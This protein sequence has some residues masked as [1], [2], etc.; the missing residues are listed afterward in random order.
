MNIA[1]SYPARMANPARETDWIREVGRRLAQTRIALGL[2]QDDLAE[3]LNVSRGALGNWEQGSRLADPGA[4]A[5]M[6]RRH[7][8]TMDWIYLGDP[9]GL[10]SQLAAKILGPRSPHTDRRRAAGAA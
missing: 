5:R 2:T 10:P 3:Q 8:V 7:R 1:I 6:A 9:S 4:I